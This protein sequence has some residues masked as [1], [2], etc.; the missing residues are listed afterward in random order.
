MCEY[1][2]HIS[3]SFVDLRTE[4]V[5]KSDTDWTQRSPHCTRCVCCCETGVA[6]WR[7]WTDVAWEDLSWRHL[8]QATLPSSGAAWP[9][10]CQNKDGPVARSKSAMWEFPTSPHPHEDYSLSVE[11][12]G[13]MGVMTGTLGGVKRLKRTVEVVRQTCPAADSGCA[14]F[15]CWQKAQGWVQFFARDQK[16]RWYQQEVVAASCR[17]GDLL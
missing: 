14:G 11:V 7:A 1:L 3:G 13:E 9:L 17:L 16:R 10:T 2:P 15:L 5:L 4:D 12:C 8:E 6:S